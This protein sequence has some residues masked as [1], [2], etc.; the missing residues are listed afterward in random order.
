MEND[1]LV[2]IVINSF[3][4]LCAL[5][6][7][8][9][10]KHESYQDTLN[11][12]SDAEDKEDVWLDQVNKGFREAEKQY[13]EYV[14]RKKPVIQ[15]TYAV[16]EARQAEQAKSRSESL[17]NE[18]K[19]KEMKFNTQLGLLKELLQGRRHPGA[20]GVI[21]D[22]YLDLKT[23]YELLN[24]A[25]ENDILSAEGT[26]GEDVKWIETCQASH[27]EVNIEYG[28]FIASEPTSSEP[29]PAPH[30]RAALKL[31]RMK[32]PTFDG[33]LK[34][35]ARFKDDFNK[36]VLPEVEGTQVA[37]VLRSCLGEEPLRFVRN[38]DD[39]IDS[40]WERLAERFGQPSV[41]TEMIMNELKR[42]K[43]LSNT[44]EKSLV[45]FIDIIESSH[46]DLTLVGMEKEVSNLSTVSL[47]EE[48]L[49]PLIRRKWAEEISKDNS[50]GI[51]EIHFHPY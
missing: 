19:M 28:K 16:M 11:L 50:T 27:R 37:Y 29:K 33:D 9:Q 36:Y 3:Q 18:R 30:N 26:T 25:H 45:E 6:D 20:K 24:T 15:D 4:K 14:E 34:K 31:E 10:D 17:L 21:E 7:Y 23:S 48:K 22:V 32:L 1:C 51:N 35:Y 44:D 47:I 2:E 43:V 39:S 40:M 12:D 13:Y 8:V 38:V 46:R 49:P 42:H 5:W 41:L